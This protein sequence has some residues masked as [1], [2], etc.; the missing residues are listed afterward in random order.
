M[1]RPSFI[2]SLNIDGGDKKI[3]FIDKE[4]GE[5]QFKEF[6]RFEQKHYDKFWK[7]LKQWHTNWWT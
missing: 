3:E 6:M 5:E 4:C 7:L 1:V 2:K